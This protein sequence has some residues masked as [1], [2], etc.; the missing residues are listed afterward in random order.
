MDRIQADPDILRL[1]PQLSAGLY[2]YRVKK[3]VLVC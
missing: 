1:E 3:H 2:F